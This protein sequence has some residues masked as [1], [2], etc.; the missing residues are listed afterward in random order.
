MANERKETKKY[1]FTVE[2]ETEQWYLDW[3]QERINSQENALYN[4]S[5]VAKVQQSPRKYAKTVN[6]LATPTITHIFD[7]ESNSSE[8]IKKFINVLTEI[9]EANSTKGRKFKYT[10]AYSNLTFELW[11]V[12]HKQSCN[13]RLTNRTQYLRHINSAYKESFESLEQYKEETNFKRCLSKLSLENVCEAICRAKKIMDNKLKD[14]EVSVQYKGFSYYKDNPALTI[15]ESIEKI[16]K[17]C[18][19]V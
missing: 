7:Y 1:V 4:V 9:K 12:L 18:D 17:E 2:G 10:P 14:G 15:W 16:L 19:L 13:G 6:P 8:H 11:M 3:L 5:I